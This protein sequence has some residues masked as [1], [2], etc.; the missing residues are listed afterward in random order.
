LRDEPT[1]IPTLSAF[2]ASPDGGRGLARDFPVRWALEETGQVCKVRLLSFDAMRSPAHLALQPFGQIPTWEEEGLTLFES[3]AI[4]LHIAE[5]H[6]GLLPDDDAA[7][8]RAK[9]WLFAAL[10]TVQPPIV[11]L[12][13]ASIVERDRPWHAQRLPML[14]DR[15]RQRLAQLASWLGE[16][17]WLEE[18]FTVGDLM[19][20]SVLRR[21]HG[22]GL[23]EAHPSVAAYVA[24]GEAR[25]AF[26]RAYAA[27]R[28]VADRAGR[29]T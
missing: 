10:D 17:A 25:P 29:A 5:R 28:A 23:L 6:P 7:R 27:Q 19:M 11:E 21:L 20:V 18:E 24:R 4:A 13:I 22:S 16:R 14:Q 12:S 1:M 9:V 3:G 8:A 2:A 26:E 15:V